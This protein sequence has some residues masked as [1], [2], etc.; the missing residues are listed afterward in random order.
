MVVG[1]EIMKYVRKD[2][3]CKKRSFYKGS[4]FYNRVGWNNNKQQYT[5]VS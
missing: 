4:L 1:V 3:E 5:E 2:V